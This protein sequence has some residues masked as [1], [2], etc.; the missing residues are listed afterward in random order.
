M[1]KVVA[2]INKETLRLIREKT[3]VSFDYLS[4]KNN[5]DV[6]VIE[7]W[8]DIGSPDCLPSILQA[9]KLAYS[10]HVPFAGLYMPPHLIPIPAL[11]N[12]HNKR[13]MP[14]GVAIDNS[15][16]NL[17]I[18]DIL[19]AREFLIETSKELNRSFTLFSLAM[20]GSNVKKWA[21]FIRSELSLSIQDQYKCSSPRQYY[22]YL[23]NKVE[24]CGVFIQCFNGVPVE[25][26]R[27]LAVYYDYLPV[28]GLNEKDRPP[29]KSFSII[30][31]LVHLMKRASMVCNDMYEVKSTDQEEVFCNAVAGEVL[32]PEGALRRELHS[33]NSTEIN[34]A[35]V[36]RIANRFS[37]SK[38]VII[39][40]MIDV[41]PPIIT[42]S[43]YQAVNS[44]IQI[45]LQMQKEMNEEMEKAGIKLPFGISASRNAMDTNSHQIGRIILSG[46][47]EGLF[48]RNDIARYLGI[49]E[50]NATDYLIEVSKWNS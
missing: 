7:G 3:Q 45:K 18:I 6:S 2:M 38:E 8:E 33:Y 23:R 32:V 5:Q 44:E 46:Y 27:G 19:K 48:S 25:E 29:A 11:P 49:N 13:T 36:E 34:L 47:E 37:V 35:T 4:K 17:A 30:H 9:K 24:N 10:L 22:L 40:R 31:E 12:L 1:G 26:V 21:D 43:Q 15:R 28:I 16:L 14:G 39:R 20:T 50:K 41:A 42:T